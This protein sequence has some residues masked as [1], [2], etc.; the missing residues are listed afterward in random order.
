MASTEK[1]KL[2][3]QPC[4]KSI[5]LEPPAVSREAL[6]VWFGAGLSADKRLLVA[7]EG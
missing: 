4:I 1:P 2:K 6:Q 3:P 5:G 7:G